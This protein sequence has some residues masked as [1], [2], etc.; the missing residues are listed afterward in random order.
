MRFTETTTLAATPEDVFALMS[1]PQ[2]QQDKADALGSLSCEAS[3]SH[4]DAGLTTV[5]TRREMPAG[6]V[7][8]FIKA[9]VRPT[10]VVH[11]RELWREPGSDGARSGEF[12]VDVVGAPIE[13]RGQ[14][15]LVRVREGCTLTF[16]FELTTSVPLFKPAVERA[17][18]TQVL[19]TITTEFDLLRRRL[20]ESERPHAPTASTPTKR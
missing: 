19:A 8:E 7:P 14:V 15:S 17:A 5:H 13:V 2:F 1:T 18:S 10:L 11:E 6:N 9:M 12:R 3:V 20:Q 4:P 16:D